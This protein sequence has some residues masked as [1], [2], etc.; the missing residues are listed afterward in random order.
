MIRDIG[1]EKG[2][3]VELVLEGV[4][5][6]IDRQVL[7]G[8]KDPLT[9]LLRNAIDHG[10]ETPDER[11]KRG[12]TRQGIIRLKALQSGNHIVL[13]V[14]DDG[15][16]INLAA[17]RRAAVKNNFITL[18][19]AETLSPEET[20]NLVF[21]S[22]LS[23][24][25]TVTDLSGRGVGMD[26][27]REQLEKLHGQVKTHTEADKGTSFIL[28]LP[29]TLAT[30]HVLMLK[31]SGQTVAVPNTTVERIL[32]FKPEEI[33]RMEG[34]PAVRIDGRVLPLISMA[35]RRSGWWSWGRWKKDWRFK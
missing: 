7:Q 32:R 19:D 24:H 20:I 28:I 9:H 16:G 22:G 27:V 14:S 13:E 30:S 26:V 3:E 15:R 1:R 29:L 2:K 5:T 12:K 25:V 17:I 35:D 23:T 21:Q 33:R 31:V 6:E 10:I 8:L 34:K 18:A 4:E 11:L